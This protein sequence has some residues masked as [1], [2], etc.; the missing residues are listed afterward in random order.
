MKRQRSKWFPGEETAT[1]IEESEERDDAEKLRVYMGKARKK[2][3]SG[4]MKV[5]P[6]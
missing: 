6:H 2:V 5:Q 4:M 1:A 3:K